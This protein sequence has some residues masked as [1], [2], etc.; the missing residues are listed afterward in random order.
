MT[1]GG[2]LDA[3]ILIADDE[4]ANIALLEGLLADEGYTRIRATCD[5]RTILP[6]ID[7]EEPDL[8]LLD[9]HM[10]HLSG[11][12]VMRQLREHLP[13]DTF[14]PILVLTADVTSEAKE[15]ALA[16]GARDFL[17]KPIDAVEVGLRIRNLLEVRELHLQQKTARAAAERAA[18]RAR[19]LSEVS[20]VLATSFDYDTM[21][22]RVTRA[23][24]PGLAEA[25]VITLDDT[26]P[27]RAGG[28]AHH[29]PERER[30]LREALGSSARGGWVSA[31]SSIDRAGEDGGS[32]EPRTDGAPRATRVTL[33][34][35]GAPAMWRRAAPLRPSSGSSG[36]LGTL[37]LLTSE[38]PPEAA[39][40]AP[41]IEE[42]AFRVGTAIENAR[43]FHEA[44]EA[45]R[46]RDEM[47]GV[48]AHD[49]RNPLNTVILSAEMLLEIAAPAESSRRALEIVLRSAR[50]MNGM[51]QDLLEIR[52]LE[53]SGMRVQPSDVELADLIS[54]AA[55]MLEPLARAGRLEL[56]MTVAGAARVRADAARVHQVVSN[57]VGNAIKFTPGGGSIAVIA[58]A[59]EAEATIRVIDSGPGIPADQLPHLFTRFWQGKAGDRRGL[60]LGLVIARAIVE[61]HGGRIWA[62][63]EPGR[64]STFSFTL[65]V[66]VDEA[67][68]SSHTTA[69]AATSG[70]STPLALH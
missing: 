63:S 52:R 53:T 2:L 69:E 44:Q 42:V 18:G 65:P 23:L 21:L 59:T 5:S 14:L 9:L 67:R 48:V 12:D 15:R 51:I 7:A 31:P 34:V 39:E 43:L 1:G 66:A 22:G 61:A 49:L 37:L 16:G 10:P 24:V 8:L 45:T 60:G 26:D 11:F 27:P 6:L 62:E 47:L 3:R 30:Q 36:A 50:A 28:V 38:C 35:E 64:G 40:D 25:C 56:V 57:L 13:P 54:E 29:D 4:P 32:G 19:L 33:P 70:A 58:E 46:A 17:T 41:L 20:R 68:G 55:E